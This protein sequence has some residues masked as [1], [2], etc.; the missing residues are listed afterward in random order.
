MS[1]DVLYSELEQSRKTWMDIYAIL[2]DGRYD[3]SQPRQAL[4]NQPVEVFHQRAIT[5]FEGLLSVRPN[6]NQ[7]VQAAILAGKASEIR[8]AL[9]SF[10][11]Y[12]Q[13]TLDGIKPLWREGLTIRD[14]NSNFSL[15]IFD[16]ENNTGNFDGSNNFT[17]LLSSLNQLTNHLALLLPLCRAESITDLSHRA[18]ALGDL[19]R[20][21]ESIRN[22]AE[23]LAQAAEQSATSAANKEKLSQDIIAQAEAALSKIQALQQQATTDTGTVSSLVEQIKTIGG[24]A[25]TLEELVNGYQSKFEKQLDERNSSFAKFEENTKLAFDMNATRDAEIERLTKLSDAMI[26]G[27]TTAGLSKSLEDTRLRYEK[28]MNSAKT[29]FQWSVVLLI[30]SAFPLAANLLPGLFGSWI[31]TFDAKAD[32]SP[33]AVLG[34]VVLLLPASW[35]TAFFTKSYADFFHLERE[36]A[37]KAALAMSVDGFKRQAENY[38]QEITAEVF[39]EI[40]SN[41]ATRQGPDPVS[42]PLYDILSKT[43]SKVLE[44]KK[45]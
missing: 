42:H 4:D 41:P 31:P 25:A 26:T 5:I 19:I 23:Q 35:L 3:L 20:N 16:G 1:I 2:K 8:P 21:V 14:G 27:A 17:Q 9:Q 32:G 7:S 13:M 18:K 15:Q 24:N 28:R 40:R 29:G 39:M 11:Q 12:G 44:H 6:D 33:Y 22:Q 43:V 10:Q 36:Y 45:E 37:H 30:V 34:K 38:Q